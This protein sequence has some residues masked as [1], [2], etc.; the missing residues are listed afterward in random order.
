MFDKL[1]IH[2]PTSPYHEKLQ[3]HKLLSDSNT[4][5]NDCNNSPNTVHE[6]PTTVGVTPTRPTR[7]NTPGAQQCTP[8]RKRTV[9]EY[10]V[11]SLAVYMDKI[12]S[13]WPFGKGEYRFHSD[14]IATMAIILINKITHV[15]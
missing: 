15:V 12:R 6:T 9:I 11:P 2:S 10:M 7:N 14:N 3:K 4:A 8:S 13:F 5:G 1:T